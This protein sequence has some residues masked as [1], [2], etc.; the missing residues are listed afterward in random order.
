MASEFIVDGTCFTNLEEFYDHVSSVLIPGLDWGRH[1]DAFTDILFWPVPEAEMPY[2]LIWRH[3]DLS[4]ERLGHAEMVQWIED[5]LQ[6]CHPSNIPELK[7]RLVS[8]KRGEGQTLFD[9]LVEIIE[10]NSEYVRLVLD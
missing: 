1:L 2:T 3:A 8:A 9:L 10:Q 7:E 4:R 5:A 6:H